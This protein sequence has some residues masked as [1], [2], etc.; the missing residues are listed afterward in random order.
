MRDFE[1]AWKRGERPALEAFLP[2]GAEAGGAEA[3]SAL[4]GLARV[5]LE[6]R[7]KAGEA[8]GAEDYFHRFP[9][10]LED[11]NAA[12]SLIA[13]ERH[14]R[15]HEADL[16]FPTTET[17]QTVSCKA[18]VVPVI[19]TPIRLAGYE[20][21][22]ELGRG[23][24]GVVYKARASAHGGIVALKMLPEVD[25]TALYR[26]KQEFRT[27]TGVSH[28]NLVS[29][30]ELIAAGNVW[31][32][33]MELVEGVDFR[34]YVRGVPGRGAEYHEGRLR[35]ALRQL[36]EGV[37]ALHAA[38]KLHRDL[39]PR[40]VL[41]T[42]AGRVVVLDF[43]LVAEL[44][45]AGEHESTERHLTG[46]VPY[47]SPEQSAA[48]PVTP[49]TDWYSVGVMLYEILTGQLP[50]QGT[51][52]E[53][54]QQKQ[55]RP[56][57]RP[58]AIAA[59]VPPDLDE[60]CQK[61]L[62]IRPEDRPEGAEILRRLAK[63]PRAEKPHGSRL[64]PGPATEFV[65]RDQQLQA[66]DA[67]YRDV[68]QGRSVSVFIHGRSGAGKSALVRQFL[69]R[70][71]E[72]ES[73]VV[74]A[75]RCYEQESVPYKAWDSVVDSLS[76]YLRRLPSLEVQAVLPRDVSQLATVFPVLRCVDLVA[77]ATG[78]SPNTPDIQ[79]TRRRTFAALRELLARLGD[80]Q[81]LVLFIDDLQ[82]GDL[83]SAALMAD[84][85][86]PPDPP[87][88]L[89]LG[90]YRSEDETRSPCLQA[91]FGLKTLEQR[92][93]VAVDPLTSEEASRLAANL[94]RGNH[95]AVEAIARE[96]GGNPFFLHELV[97][98]VKT[99][100]P[101]PPS[102]GGAAGGAA[103]TL[104]LEQIVAQRIEGLPEAARRLLEVAA[105]SGRP[106][107]LEQAWEAAEL[108]GNQTAL[109]ALLKSGRFIRSTGSV[110]AGEIETY[111]DRIRETIVANLPLDRLRRRHQALAQVLEAAGNVDPEVL[112]MHYQGADEPERA[113]ALF[114]RAA[115]QADQALAFE[116]AV[117]LY[118]AALGL[119]QT[120]DEQG[121]ALRVKLADALV[122]AGRGAEAARE[123][124]QAA[125]DAPDAET[126]ELRCNAAL[127][128]LR[129]GYVDEGLPVL[130]TVLGSLGM[131][132]TSTPRR[133]LLS[134]LLRRAQLWM[135][136]LG[137]RP[138][139][140]RDIP[141][142]ELRRIDLCWSVS[143]CL[144][145]ID[146]IRGADF[147]TRG[148]L[149]ALRA[150]EPIRIARSL[151][152][153]AAHVATA[154]GKT[155]PRGKKLLAIAEDVAQRSGHPYAKGW[156]ALSKGMIAYFEDRWQD[157]LAYCDEAAAIFRDHCTGVTWELDTAHTF[158]L[159]ALLLQGEIPEL[160]RR[161]SI[162][163]DQARERGDR[164]A[165]TYLSTVIMAVVRLAADDPQGMKLTLDQVRDQWSQAGFHIQ[166]YHCLY[167]GC[168][169]DLYQGETAAAW[170][171]VTGMWSKFSN[172]L[173]PRIQNLRWH[174]HFMR[175]SIAVAAALTAADPRPLLKAAERD[176]RQLRR[177]RLAPAAAC[178]EFIFAALANARGDPAGVRRHLTEAAHGFQANHQGLWAAA[179]G[180]RL[181]KLLGGEEGA[182]WIANAEQWMSTHG[183]K[184]H[185]RMT[186][187]FAPGF[188][189]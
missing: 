169:V 10:L 34:H 166:H 134:L 108:E 128:M 94:L 26:F 95:S 31:C 170:Q 3:H 66:L 74:L 18:S 79:E 5:E 156:V 165:E 90:C 163:L 135:R 46:T 19:D 24:M 136:G 152:L 81:P 184:N 89:F 71:A 52:L 29:L 39:K 83:D 122:N 50:F 187:A 125:R 85:L 61:L 179:A 92:R 119:R 93:L 105:V 22:G 21:L 12:V 100:P 30:Y 180:F 82:W 55:E 37:S 171:R 133:A 160:T 11:A 120:T 13:V 20:I 167:A 53:V 149:L 35:S 148:L 23:G 32:F 112:A 189:D 130:H 101:S 150:G 146:T 27:L 47:M 43:G 60:L 151:A 158:A 185:V 164:Y 137:F 154:G 161:W 28:P 186:A 142:D 181:G 40:N 172:S 44:G 73:A 98:H 70:L 1:L 69:N 129:S 87:V 116:R 110:E 62:A 75:G 132:M 145:M 67:A 16:P 41:V 144:T 153:E 121:Q 17:F 88:F 188:V 97:H 91:L 6:L 58:G 111:H 4:V 63:D 77:R 59:G 126:I 175:G 183:I 123:Y 155:I 143:T 138:R 15:G 14:W 124:L 103:P 72:R 178:S 139:D 8:A 33:T 107:R 118:R 49:A 102:E 140:A 42:E 114:A 48:K 78:R 9:A 76:R 84:L 162:L 99:T 106:L 96:S 173:L 56:P 51:C 174:M 141:A 115:V 177:E 131:K 109:L 182:A 117:Q 80:R 176:A 168:L 45:Q 64:E 38:G 104:A 54:L 113:G 25:A 86:R 36:V 68:K 7:L 147:L 57:P 65:G 157:N 2:G 159:W 127:Q